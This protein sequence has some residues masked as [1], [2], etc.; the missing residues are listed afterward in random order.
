M[1][2]VADRLDRLDL[3]AGRRQAAADLERV[4]RRGMGAYSRSQET[5][6]RIGQISIPNALLN[7]T[8]PS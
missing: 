5:G 6:T 3:E 2:V 7:R 8:S 4:I 1:D